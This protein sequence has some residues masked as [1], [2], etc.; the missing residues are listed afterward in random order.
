MLANQVNLQKLHHRAANV[1]SIYDSTLILLA[2]QVASIIRD[3][4]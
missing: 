3:E 4:A 1:N 2:G